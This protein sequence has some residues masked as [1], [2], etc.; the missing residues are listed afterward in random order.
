M[1]G[2]KYQGTQHHLVEQDK[3]TFAEARAVERVTG[4]SFGQISSDED[5]ASSATVTQALL[6]VS[7]KR[8]EPELKF[9]DL[10]DMAI[11]DFEWDE[12]EPEQGEAP[13]PTDA[14]EA[15]SPSSD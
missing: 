13:D 2:F 10:D 15:P 14:D 8:A 1:A 12:P 7:M 9:S 11:G 6:W 3:L 4:H 5:V